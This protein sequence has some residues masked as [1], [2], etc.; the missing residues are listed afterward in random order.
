MDQRLN[1][2]KVRDVIA[3][4]LHIGRGAA[5]LGLRV[6]GQAAG[7]AITALGRLISPG[8]RAR[9]DDVWAATQSDVATPETPPAPPPAAEAVAAEPEPVVVPTPAPAHV[10][11]EPEL[12]ASF[13][14]PGA[15]DG[16]GATVHVAE[17]WQGYEHMRADDVIARLV[18]ASPE[19][20]VA[21]ELYERRHRGRRTVLTAAE[22]QLRRA[23]ALSEHR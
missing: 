18:A 4:P 16:P 6:A 11:E 15:E 9:D 19:E 20:L 14:E 17:P 5:G 8:N 22:R 1:D 13:A 21:V 2:H 7:M 10:S 3:L 12:V 23:P